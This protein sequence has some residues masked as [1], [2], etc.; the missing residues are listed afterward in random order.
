MRSH[1]EGQ[2]VE[3]V[4]IVIGERG[5]SRRAACADV[6]IGE[7]PR[8]EDAEALCSAFL[9]NY[10][11]LTLVVLASWPTVLLAFNTCE[12]P[13]SGVDGVIGA[14]AVL[15]YFGSACS[16]ADCLIDARSQPSTESP[17]AG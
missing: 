14:L 8:L 7:L 4:V 9:A 12:Q 5:W 13:S 15:A 11:G 2:C 17:G 3:P 6:L 16:L 10:P 1:G